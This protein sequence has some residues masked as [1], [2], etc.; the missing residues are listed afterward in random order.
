MGRDAVQLV[1]PAADSILWSKPAGS[2]DV[3]VDVFPLKHP[4][5]RH[6]VAA[7]W[8]STL[9]SA[10]YAIRRVDGWGT[11]GSAIKSWGLNAQD[12][13]LGL[14]VYGMTGHP[15]T[16][17]HFLALDPINNQWGW[18]V[19]PWAASKTALF[20]T[21]TGSPITIF[22]TTWQ[23]IMRTAWLDNASPT[24]VFYNND[25]VNTSIAGP[26]TCSGCSLL[27]VTAD[28][29]SNV[30]FFGLCDGPSVDARRVVRFSTAGA[31]ETVLE[32][33]QFGAQSRLSRLGQ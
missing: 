28:P 18:D 27:H 3:P 25:N 26:I 16:P 20:G 32:G 11:D 10:P 14:S 21:A 33:A 22:A 9:G 8:S 7:G 13:P 23:G 31:C 6:V 5:G 15:R 4:D 2:Q 19:D 29:T 17:T 24:S 30:R 1:D 12:L